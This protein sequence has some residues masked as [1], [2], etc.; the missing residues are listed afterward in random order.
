[1]FV[2]NIFNIQN[3]CKIILFY[4]KKCSELNGGSMFCKSLSSKK[5]I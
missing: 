4:S 5:I 3:D 2:F 1:M